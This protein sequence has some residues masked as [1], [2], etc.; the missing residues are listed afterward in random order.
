MEVSQKE[1]YKFINPRNVTVTASITG[2]KEMRSDF[3]Y[4]NGILC[5]Y[6]ITKFN[7]LEDK[8]YYLVG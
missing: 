3:K 6:V 8:S 1:F 2:D 5:G 4:R 7:P